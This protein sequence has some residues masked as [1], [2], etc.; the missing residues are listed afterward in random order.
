MSKSTFKLVRLKEAKQ[1]AVKLRVE[2]RLPTYL[3][4]DKLGVNRRTCHKWLAGYPLTEEELRSHS[5]PVRRTLVGKRYG[6]LRVV[7]LV[8]VYNPDSSTPHVNHYRCVCDCGATITRP[9]GNL[10]SGNTRSCGCLRL[11]V[12]HTWKTSRKLP[13][14]VVRLHEIGRYYRRNAKVAGREWQLTEEELKG[15]VSKPCTYCG[16]VDTERY[17][18]I[19]RVDNSE[20]YFLTNVVP[21][22]NICNQAKSTLTLHDF[23]E[24]V[25]RLSKH[26]EGAKW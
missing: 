23:R 12:Q 18:G 26:F 17:I 2:E 1:V 11:E 5:R 6:R 10:Y 16:Y 8:H 3:I 9:Y 7:E 14:G 20:G 21:C 15:I 22:C 24:W 4:A 13:E 19:D 25:R